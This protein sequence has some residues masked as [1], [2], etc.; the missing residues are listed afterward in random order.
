MG[1][2]LG[3]VHVEFSWGSRV[4]VGF[5]WV[6]VGFRGVFVGCSR[7]FSLDFRGSFGVSF[8]CFRGF[9]WVF[10]GVFVGF[11]GIF[12]G[13]RG[14]NVCFLVFSWICRRV[15]DGF[16]GVCL[17][18]VCVW[19][20][21]GGVV[22]GRLEGLV[23]GGRFFVCVAWGLWGV[24]VGFRISWGFEVFGGGAVWRVGRGRAFFLFICLFLFCVSG[25]FQSFLCVAGCSGGVGG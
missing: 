9:S 5:S 18:C 15:F 25:G 22:L 24:F 2:S 19:C 11:R 10:L 4:F 17:L 21:F 8:S 14:F 23:W 12:V 3:W 16:V 1:I 20:C 13:V 7:G 6:F